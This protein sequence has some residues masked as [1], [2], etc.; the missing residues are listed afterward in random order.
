MGSSSKMRGRGVFFMMEVG[1]ETKRTHFD[2]AA[3]RGD[4]A[5]FRLPSRQ[6][7]VSCGLTG[8]LDLES[9]PGKLLRFSS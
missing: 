4:C 5:R 6:A 7:Q 2:V 3:R 9:K 8:E 1:G